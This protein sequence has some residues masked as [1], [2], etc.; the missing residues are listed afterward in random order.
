MNFDR[1]L[2]G[3]VA[4][5]NSGNA[6]GFQEFAE[7]IGP[8]CRAFLSGFGYSRRAA[9]ERTPIMAM[10]IALEARQAV[11]PYSD[12]LEL[13]LIEELRDE[14]RCAVELHNKLVN[15]TVVSV[16][17]LDV[18]S[19][20][21]PCHRVGG[22]LARVYVSKAQTLF[23]LG[24]GSGDGLYASLI[25]GVSLGLLESRARFSLD[26]MEIV[27]SLDD[28][29]RDLNVAPAYFTLMLALW[30]P[31]K[32]TFQFSNNGHPNAPLCSRN[33]AAF[34]IWVSG[35]WLGFPLPRPHSAP[36]PWEVE[37]GDVVLLYSDGLTGQ[38][39]PRGSTF[40]AERLSSALGRLSHL[41]AREIAAGL[42]DEIDSFAGRRPRSDDQSLILAKV[43]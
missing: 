43:L 18:F 3:L 42:W 35:N 33:G 20:V 2:E 29:L 41:P 1:Y 11:P 27:V 7:G 8:V 16:P 12:W 14:L 36:V 30:D 28:I 40:G 13:K 39:G 17:G 26:V 34:S 21:R 9:T 23:A 37:S 22:D 4:R 6:S 10:N 31:C 32:R 24:D 19:M 25:S 5:R 15:T 38:E